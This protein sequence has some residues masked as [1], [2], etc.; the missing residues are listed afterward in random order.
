MCLARVDSLVDPIDECAHFC[1]NRA[2]VGRAVER[3]EAR[4]AK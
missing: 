2:C 4:Y 3:P 1:V